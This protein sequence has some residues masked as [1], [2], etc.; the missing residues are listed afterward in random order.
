MHRRPLRIP[1]AAAAL[2]A[3]ALSLPSPEQSFAE[4]GKEMIR[5]GA[6]GPTRTDTACALNA[7]PLPIG[8][9]TRGKQ[10]Q[11]LGCKLEDQVGFKPTRG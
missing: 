7:F 8:V 11:N 1:C 4:E 9:Q 6:S 10:L 5:I 3:G 2:S